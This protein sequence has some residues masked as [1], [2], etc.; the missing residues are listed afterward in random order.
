M[1]A[2]GAGTDNRSGY[3]DPT[4]ERTVSLVQGRCFCHPPLEEI[5]PVPGL[6]C[7]NLARNQMGNLHKLVIH[8]TSEVFR[9]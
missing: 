4:V 1:A 5:K 7:V 2:M 3:K 8:F 6:K 9:Q